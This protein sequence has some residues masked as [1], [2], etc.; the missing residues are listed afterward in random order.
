MFAKFRITTVDG[1]KER[2]NGVVTFLGNTPP[3]FNPGD[4]ANSHVLP[5]TVCV[6][7]QSTLDVSGALQN[8]KLSRSILDAEQ[9]P[10]SIPDGIDVAH[11]QIFITLF[12]DSIVVDNAIPGMTAAAIKT[13]VQDLFSAEGMI[14]HFIS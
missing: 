7:F 13:G 11:K 14:A 5:A 3:P 4:P 1:F 6:N 12:P 8:A 10:N 2:L 9:D